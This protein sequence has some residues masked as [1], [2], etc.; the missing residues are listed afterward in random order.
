MIIILHFKTC[1]EFQLHGK[2]RNCFKKY[3]LDLFKNKTY[4]LCNMYKYILLN[5]YMLYSINI[6]CNV[7]MYIYLYIYLYLHTFL[8]VFI[9]IHIY[10]LAILC[11]LNKIIKLLMI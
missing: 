9:H 3:N 10:D 8:V 7:C 2:D 4:F 1:I 6:S 11:N 5:M